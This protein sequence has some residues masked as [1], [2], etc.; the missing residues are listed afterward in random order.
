MTEYLFNCTDYENDPE[1]VVKEFFNSINLQGKFLWML[2][3]LVNRVGCG[4]NETYCSFPDFQDSDPKCHFEGVMFGVW[5]GEI[6]VTESVGLNYTLL[7]CKSYL[8]LHPEDLDKVN[9]LIDK[10]KTLLIP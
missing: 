3:F 1:W 7:A 2:Q 4:A 10:I 8:K 5:N 6:V 9:D